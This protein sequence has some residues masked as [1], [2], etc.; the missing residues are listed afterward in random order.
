M[1][2]HDLVII[3][4]GPAGLT[5]AL[6]ACRSGLKTLVLEMGLPGGQ[7]LLTSEIENW[8]GTILTT[9]EEL[10][11]RMRVQAAASGAAFQTAEVEG[12]KAG[13]G[14]VKIIQTGSG[15]I[16]AN[17]VILA[18]G[19][20]HRKLDDSVHER[21]HGRGLSYCA[22]CDGG[23]YKGRR[24]AVVGGVNTALE[25][26]AYLAANTEKIYLIHR[27]D[28]FRADKVLVERLAAYPKIEPVMDSVIEAVEGEDEVRAVRVKNVQTGRGQ[29]IDVDGVF[30]FVG[31]SP[32]SGFLP[33]EVERAPGGWVKTDARLQTS[34]PGVFAA[35]D[36]RDTP[37]RQI[38]TAAADGA[39][40]AMFA[41][42]YIE[43]TLLV[44]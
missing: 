6:Y 11:E 8:P 23:F 28:K 29:T 20:S 34:W 21:F 38:V 26:A 37:L 42:R 32:H 35:G 31:V 41:Y 39:M 10:S 1:P 14:G 4:A 7:M 40:A 43:G 15:D 25:S 17:T 3:G 18:T 27:R 2:T 12:L 33:P 9:G 16:A 22:V 30:V 44:M 13:D 5:A 24:V 19:A 36:V